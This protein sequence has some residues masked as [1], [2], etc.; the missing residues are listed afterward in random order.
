M[1]WFIKY[2]PSDL[3]KQAARQPDKAFILL[4][5]MFFSLVRKERRKRNFKFILLNPSTVMRR[6]LHGE[7]FSGRL[8]V[9]WL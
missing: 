3:S 5:S 8:G 1:K 7:L 2:L 6:H 9:R 4:S